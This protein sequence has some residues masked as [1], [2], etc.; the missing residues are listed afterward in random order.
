MPNCKNCEHKKYEYA[1]YIKQ[2]VVSCDLDKCVYGF[3]EKAAEQRDLYNKQ[4]R[5]RKGG[6][7]T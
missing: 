3:P 4:R 1:K 7:S 6:D 5:E 2:F